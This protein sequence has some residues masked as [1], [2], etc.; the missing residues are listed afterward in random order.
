MLFLETRSGGIAA[1]A[2]DVIGGLNERATGNFHLIEYHVGREPRET[3][4]SEQ[5]VREFMAA[6]QSRIKP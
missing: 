2:I 5:A 3:R 6:Q 4:A 1:S